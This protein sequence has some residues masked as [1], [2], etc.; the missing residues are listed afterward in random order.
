MKPPPVYRPFYART[1]FVLFLLAAG[2][3]VAYGWRVTQIQPGHLVKDFHL[4][5]PL[6]SALLQPDVIT[7]ET[8][9][10]T[11]ETVFHMADTAA[12]EQA[13][14]PS[15]DSSPS[16]K[17]SRT[18]GRIGDALTVEG[19]HLEPGRQG[20]LYWVNSI[21]QEF[22]LAA[23][24]TDEAGHFYQAIV[25]PPT[26]RGDRQFL[27]AVLTWE[28]GGWQFSGTL[29][30]TG[31]KIVETIFLGLM[32]TLM[33]LLLAGPLSFL[34]AR[35]L[36][37]GHPAGTSLYHLTR[38]LFNVLRA[39]EPLIM[40]ILFAVWVG[41]GPFAGVLA[42]GLHS[43][44]ALGKLFSEQIE[45]IDSGPV[46]AIKATGAAPLSVVLYGV[47]PQ[48]LPQFLAL[49]IYRWDINVRMSTI[50]GFV[51]GGGIGF[52]LQQWI[53]LLKYHQAGTALWA[54][55]GVVIALDI[56]SARL[57]AKIIGP[58]T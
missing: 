18:S 9:S 55:A 5:K 24:E 57:R 10:V 48:V 4:V 25:V 1:G 26:A 52:L 27:R 6:V 23:I 46:E 44:A 29:K 7:R 13:I 47:L 34:G 28:T 53:N 14:P 21:E 36:M 3:V 2:V 19:F 15:T 22:P 12:P 35:N 37:T 38:T 8:A 45:S 20:Q 56:L 30:L 31:E 40:A 39:I 33:A 49:G 43:T 32:A 54:I 16:L 42:L 11:T 50:I 51:G 58:A 17:L 41:I